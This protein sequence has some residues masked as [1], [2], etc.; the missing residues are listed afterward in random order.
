MLETSR[1]RIASS[2]QEIPDFIDCRL[3]TAANVTTLYV[4]H[5]L[6]LDTFYNV[7]ND[8]NL[9]IICNSHKCKYLFFLILSI[10]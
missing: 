2:R 6:Q 8:Y 3:Y 1:I 9:L 10:L 7:F 4:L 5:L